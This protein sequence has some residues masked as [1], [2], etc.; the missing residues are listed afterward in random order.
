MNDL[1]SRPLE[2]LAKIPWETLEHAYGAAS[3]VPDLLRALVSNEADTRNEALEELYGN[4]WHQGTVYEASAPAVPF[5]IGLLNTAHIDRGGVLD[6]LGCLAGGASYLDV[7]GPMN[8]QRHERDNP[9]HLAALERELKWVRE[10]RSAVLAGLP[11]YVQL[12]QDDEAQVRHHVVALLERLTEEATTVGTVLISRIMSEPEPNVRARLVQALVALWQYAPLLQTQRHE[13]QTLLDQRLDVHEHPLVR[14]EA[15]LGVLS[16]ADDALAQAALETVQETIAVCFEE[17]NALA[18]PMQR[19]A[20]ALARDPSRQVAVFLK[21]LREGQEAVRRA[22]VWVLEDLCKDRRSVPRQVAGAFADTLGDE[23]SSVRKRVASALVAIG[24]ASRVAVPALLQALED[25][26]PFV[27][28]WAAKTLGKLR[29]AEATSKFPKLLEDA[30]TTMAAADA[31][32]AAGP[33]AANC[34]EMLMNLLTATRNVSGSLRLEANVLDFDQRRVRWLLALGGIGP[35]AERAVPVMLEWLVG[36]G[37]SPTMAAASALSDLGEHA[38]A[39]VPVLR[40]ALRSSDAA[41]VR[42]CARALGHIGGA[43]RPAMRDLQR[44]LRAE[45][46]H[47]RAETALALLKIGVRSNA[48]MQALHSVLEPGADRCWNNSAVVSACMALAL[49]GKPARNT[50]PKLLPHMQNEL[51]W[52]SLPAMRA[53]W[54]ITG[55][56]KSIVPALGALLEARG[57]HLAALRLLEEIGS[58]APELLP[59]IRAIANDDVRWVTGGVT[60]EIID[61]DEAAQALAMRLLANA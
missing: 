52:V 27:R 16:T 15:A 43:A 4:I 21:L 50:L 23:L 60:D 29:L 42:V 41:V 38:Q 31:V 33:L 11:V 37:V 24:S 59:V 32:R 25:E 9:E 6:L 35:S 13:L 1:P 8:R 45:D 46:R 51:S 7:H 49:I 61:Q 18:D 40:Q 54:K 20:H 57:G 19:L 3:N 30:Q 36:P 2:E 28:G 22:S 39:A 26:E 12:L 47:L 10:T 14:F 55:D 56:S 48:V 44:L 53:V 58:V 34:V 17:Y 5:L